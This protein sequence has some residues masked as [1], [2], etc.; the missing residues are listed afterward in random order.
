MLDCF[1]YSLIQVCLEKGPTVVVTCMAEMA[2]YTQP[3]TV[4]ADGMVY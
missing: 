3:P 4:V 2:A 1:W